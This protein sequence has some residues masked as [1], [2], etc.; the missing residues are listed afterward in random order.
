MTKNAM[1][2]Y[3]EIILRLGINLSSG[4]N[5]LIKCPV[6]HYQ[7]SRIITTV[8][9]QLGARKVIIEYID[10][11]NLQSFIDNTP[12]NELKNVAQWQI[13]YDKMLV[14]QNYKVVTLVAP[15]QDKVT[16]DKFK[17]SEYR[18]GLIEKAGKHRQRT[19]S[20]QL[21]WTIAALP[22][23]QWADVVFPNC[24]N[25]LK[26]LEEY[27]MTATML[28]ETDPIQAW[29][30]HKDKLTAVSKKLNQLNF[31]TLQISTCLGT[32]IEIGLV[33]NHLWKMA[34]SGFISNLPTE[35]VYTM[36][37]KN[38]VNGIVVSSKPLLVNNILYQQ[39]K[40]EFKDGKLIKIEG[41]IDNNLSKLIGSTVGGDMLGEIALVDKNSKVSQ[42][43]TLFYEMLYDENAGAHI[44][45]GN[46][47]AANLKPSLGSTEINEGQNVSNIH[48]DIVFGTNDINVV[49]KCGNGKSIN[50]MKDG[51]FS[52]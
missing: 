26:K 22:N 30:Q 44:A 5:V 25:N 13:S 27:V 4:D 10:E 34:G 29:E 21:A 40:L 33:S 49:G 15:H 35:E 23:K 3:S 28:D 16:I 20:D 50:V 11:V 41:D 8:A 32:N 19:N 18:N 46:S 43:E 7:F 9:Y 2:E 36:P 52:I 6:N 38:A 24:K 1:K 14:Q 17:H 42:L 12:T 31:E 47:F 48:I 51:L 37:N 45:L 39:L